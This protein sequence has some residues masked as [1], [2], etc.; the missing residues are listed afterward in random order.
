MIL[1][2]KGDSESYRKLLTELN[3]LLENYAV[4]GVKR[5]NPHGDTSFARDIV[6]EVLLAI[7]AKRHTYDL[8]S[9]SCLGFLA[10][11]VT[12]SSTGNESTFRK[13]RYSIA[14]LDG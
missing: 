13:K 7:H 11:L 12:N 1:A 10:L 4:R 3:T 2:Q 5:S 6:Q 14:S 8:L 9:A